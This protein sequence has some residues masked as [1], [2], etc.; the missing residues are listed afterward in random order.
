MV[1]LAI[2]LFPSKMLMLPGNKQLPVIVIEVL[3][4]VV[5]LDGEVIDGGGS[6]SMV[7]V[8]ALLGA[9]VAPFMVSVAVSE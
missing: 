9:L 4:V 7:M 3:V 1:V 2:S 8:T 6:L 5:P